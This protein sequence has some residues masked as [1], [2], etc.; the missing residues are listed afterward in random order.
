MIETLG[1]VTG[2]RIVDLGCGEGRF[3][4]MLCERGVSY[5]LGIDLCEEMIEGARAQKHFDAEDYLV[6]NIETLD[7]VEADS[8]DIAVSYVSLV[9][10]EDFDG[11]VA[12]S[13]RVLKPGG[14]FIVCNLAPMATA[15]NKRITDPDG[16]RTAFRVDHY[17]DEGPRVCRIM[18]LE[19]TNF[20]RTLSTQ[21]NGFLNAGF[22]LKGVREPF[23]DKEDLVRFPELTN[24]LRAPGF[25]IFDL[26][27]PV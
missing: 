6:G 14:R 21:I 10:V 2:L 22:V 16:T 19:L 18:G 3:C 13:F 27:K 24:E 4:R 12:S 1:D 8:F 23:P 26:L 17:L 9:D 5:T 25:V 11:V 15:M 20:H 7:G